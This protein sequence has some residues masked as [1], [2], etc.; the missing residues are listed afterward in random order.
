[1]RGEPFLCCYFLYGSNIRFVFGVFLYIL[2]SPLFICLVL[3]SVV[4]DGE[5]KVT[6]KNIS[7]K[8]SV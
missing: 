6:R 3:S 4:N 8:M 5:F 7:Q 1:M 2:L